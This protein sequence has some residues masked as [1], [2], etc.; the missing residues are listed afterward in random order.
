MSDISHVWTLIIIVVGLTVLG[1][2]G[3]R[4]GVLSPAFRVSHVSV[5]NDDDNERLD[6][7]SSPLG[8]CL[9]GMARQPSL[10]AFYC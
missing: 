3:Q 6:M 8:C 1:Y 2:R 4:L 9:K 10:K 7:N 5:G